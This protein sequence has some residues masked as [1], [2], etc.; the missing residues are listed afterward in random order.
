VACRSVARQRLRQTIRQQPV[1][2]NRVTV[3]SVRSVPRCYKQDGL[4]KSGVLRRQLE[5]G[6]V[7][8]RW[9]PACED[10]SLGAGERPLVK[11]QQTEKIRY[12]L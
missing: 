1:N 8:V 2:C 12:M 7:G 4:E 11:T 6:K 5:E 3:F 9:S 10:V